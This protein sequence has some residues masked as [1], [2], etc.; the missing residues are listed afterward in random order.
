MRHGK[1]AT[2]AFERR[3]GPL[4]RVPCPDM[5]NKL[6]Q[7]KQLFGIAVEKSVI[8]DPAKASGQ[9]M[10]DHKIQKLFSFQRS[11]A[12]VARFAF[13]IAECHVSISAGKD[14]SFADDSS[15]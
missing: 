11:V 6:D 7:Q 12:C 4:L 5:Q 13:G 1:F 9:D 14:I 10:P 2:R 15:V 8:P 3:S